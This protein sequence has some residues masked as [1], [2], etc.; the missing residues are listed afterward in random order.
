MTTLITGGTGFVGLALAERLLQA[1]EQVVLF[2]RPMASSGE[3]LARSLP[4]AR[5]ICGD[6]RS[7]DDLETVFASEEI[8]RVV[9]AAA[10]TPG[11]E[12]EL[13][14][15]ALIF[16][17]NVLGT[18]GLLQRCARAPR[19]KRVVV[20]SSVAIYGA[21]APAASGFYEE[22]LSAPG[23]SGLYGISKLAAEQASL[24]LAQLHGLD[25]R[26][27]RLGPVYGRW[28]H[29][30][31]ARERL[32]PHHQVASAALAGAEIVLPRPMTAD[33]IYA[34]DAA[35]ALA[36]IACAPTL[37]HAVYQI[38]GGRLTD[39]QQ[40]CAA[41]AHHLPG[42]RW[43]TATQGEAATVHYALPF[44]RAALSIARLATE[45]DYAAR[46]DLASAAE[47][48]L[49]WRAAGANAGVFPEG[50]TP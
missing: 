28:E 3:R 16:D 42:L 31:G 23:P 47:D 33:W 38:G 22:D 24:R 50:Q 37:A 44:D 48:Y 11:P 13:R 1:G 46:F 25:V 43:R 10:M 36:L 41:L 15:A 7:G 45:L 19:V 14:D 39:L 30:S 6:I 5:V 35:Q 8:D 26:V 27:A 18:I 34:R 29:A 21:T 2:D 9:H 12:R 49:A 32:S 17:V 4:A 40:W 20:V